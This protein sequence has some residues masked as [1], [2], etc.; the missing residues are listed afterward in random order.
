M[1]IE[2]SDCPRIEIAPEGKAGP[3][4]AAPTAADAGEATRWPSPA[5]RSAGYAET[6]QQGAMVALVAVSL[7]I[8]LSVGVVTIFSVMSATL[9]TVDA[10]VVVGLIGLTGVLL[11]L[12]ARSSRRLTC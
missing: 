11:L 9:L 4:L 1:A 3:T 2:L 6:W 5:V 12:L 7:Y 8:L 10:I